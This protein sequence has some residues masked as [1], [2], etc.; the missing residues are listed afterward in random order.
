M[1]IT[2]LSFGS[3]RPCKKRIPVGA[4]TVE[5]AAALVILIM[6]V[7]LP[8]LDFGIL[9]VHWMLSQEIVTS[10][11]RKLALCQ[12]FS[13]ALATLAADTSMENQLSAIGGV[14]PRNIKCL[15]VISQLQKPYASFI[16]DAAK[17]IPSG[18]LPGGLNSPCSYE[19][20]LAVETEF[21][22]LILVKFYKA[23][24]P[25]LT[26]PFTAV[27]EAKVPWENYSCDPAT[28]QFFMNE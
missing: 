25:G 23:N 10:H 14:K 12:S 22:P 19:I 4:Q 5:F 7:A 26:K 11:A 2:K 16:T 8:M 9:P 3:R 21:N 27:I 28:N 13:Q 24:I 18:W 15:M 1:T 20:K 6:A 17:T